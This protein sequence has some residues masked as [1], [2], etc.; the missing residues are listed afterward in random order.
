VGAAVTEADRDLWLDAVAFVAA[1]YHDD[2]EALRAILVA[3]WACPVFL[4]R[5][6]RTLAELVLMALEGRPPEDVDEALASLRQA[7]LEQG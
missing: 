5:L 1:S 6:I 7:V 2:Q 3:N 4:E